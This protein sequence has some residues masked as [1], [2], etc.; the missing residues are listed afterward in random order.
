[1]D[2]GRRRILSTP[3][4]CGFRQTIAHLLPGKNKFVTAEISGYAGGNPL[5][6]EE[7]CHSAAHDHGD[8]HAG[9]AHGGKAWLEK[10]I[11]AANIKLQ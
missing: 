10:L 2:G 3:L 6:V 9:R 7:L 1:M 5:F 4:T 11:E 8:R